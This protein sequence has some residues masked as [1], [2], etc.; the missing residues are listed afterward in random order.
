V[1]LIRTDISKELIVVIIRMKRISEL[2]T[3]LAV[4]ATEAHCEETLTIWKGTALAVS[5]SEAHCEE[6][7]TIWKESAS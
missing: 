5:A 1:A 6:T 3:T 2:G 7:L 4:T